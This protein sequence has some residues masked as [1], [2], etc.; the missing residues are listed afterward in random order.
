MKMMKKKYVPIVAL[1]LAV[2]LV[3]GIAYAADKKKKTKSVI[4]EPG[5]ISEE[6][7]Q[8]ELLGRPE[9]Q[10]KKRPATAIAAK[11]EATKRY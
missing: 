2:L 10:L 8:A 1:S 11:S 4:P 7:L 6:T 9:K 3:G 5:E